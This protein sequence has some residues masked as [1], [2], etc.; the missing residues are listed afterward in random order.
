MIDIE[1][2]VYD[3]VRT[4]LITALSSTYTNLMTYSDYPMEMPKFPAVVIAE[5]DNTTYRRGQDETLADNYANVTYQIDVYMNGANPKGIARAVAKVADASMLGM[6]FTRTM[7][8]QTPNVDRNI[9]R[10]TG[11]YTAV[12]KAGE[13]VGN[14][15]VYRVYRK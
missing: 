10:I 4:A 8:T 2:K 9:Y 12:V 14:D 1:N 5:M 7:L 11:R 15:T 3:T 13:A 6:K